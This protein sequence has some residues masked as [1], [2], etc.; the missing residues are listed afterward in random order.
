MRI[1]CVIC[2]KKIYLKKLFFVLYLKNFTIFGA[3]FQKG[4]WM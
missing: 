4:L 3:Q 2:V 1:I